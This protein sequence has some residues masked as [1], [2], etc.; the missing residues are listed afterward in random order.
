MPVND[1]IPVAVQRAL[2]C[3]ER[4]SA[5]VC[6]VKLSFMSC[7][8]PLVAFADGG[9]P[10]CAPWH[11]V[12]V[13]WACAA[14]SACVRIGRACYG[15]GRCSD[16]AACASWGA[17]QLCQHVR[18]VVAVSTIRARRGSTARA[19]AGAVPLRIAPACL[20]GPHTGAVA[21]VKLIYVL[22]GRCGLPRCSAASVAIVPAITM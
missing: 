16:P 9:C 18:S 11:M 2:L 15:T 20:P 22:S 14:R 5:C 10:P 7:C 21:C 19:V 13:G 8:C 12:R 6:T 17:G 3:G 4:L 1:L